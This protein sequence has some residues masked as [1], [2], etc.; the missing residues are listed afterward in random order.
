MRVKHYQKLSE[1]KKEDPNELL[2]NI[3]NNKFQILSQ[4]INDINDNNI[5][6]IFYKN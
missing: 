2:R 6:L 4:E 1:A 5:K 3:M